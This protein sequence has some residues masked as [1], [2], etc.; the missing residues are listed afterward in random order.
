MP[1]RKF[2]LHCGAIARC[3]VIFT[4]LVSVICPGRVLG[5]EIHVAALNGDLAKVTGLLK[6]NPGLVLS[7]DSDGNMPLH[8]AAFKGQR[9]TVE[10]LLAGGAQVDALGNGERTPL[11]FAVIADKKDVTQVLL[12]AHADVNRTTTSAFLYSN[13]TP[14][15]L[16]AIY[17]RVQVAEVLLTY[18]P[19][20][21]A[22]HVRSAAQQAD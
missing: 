20:S 12:N 8:L 21:G 3:T 13:S 9:E 11:H 19:G 7:K 1:I 15:M 18:K 14:L 17:G 5:G 6:D 4:L 10:V 22:F 2:W 16:S